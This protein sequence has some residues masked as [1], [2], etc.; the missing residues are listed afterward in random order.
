MRAKL[1]N[2]FSIVMQLIFQPF[3]NQTGKEI[4]SAHPPQIAVTGGAD[5]TKAR[6][7]QLLTGEVEESHLAGR[8]TFW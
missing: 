1:S 7:S 4:F 2:C 5:T 3:D 6:C 8:E